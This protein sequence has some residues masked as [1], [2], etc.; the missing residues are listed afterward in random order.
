MADEARKGLS[1]DGWI[2]QFAAAGDFT[3]VRNDAS[4]AQEFKHSCAQAVRC[5]G[6]DKQHPCGET[7]GAPTA[8]HKHP[9]WMPWQH[10]HLVDVVA[11]QE[12]APV[13]RKC[14]VAPADRGPDREQELAAV[15]MQVHPAGHILRD[16]RTGVR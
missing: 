8:L 5:A 10:M 14:H 1:D 7:A 6:S 15:G 9:S 16:D 4:S 13:G 3:E 2:R 11:H 12:P